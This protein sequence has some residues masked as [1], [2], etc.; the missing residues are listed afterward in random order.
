M[1]NKFTSIF[2][3]SMS[4]LLGISSVSSISQVSAEGNGGNSEGS[5][6]K[7]HLDSDLL[8]DEILTV[9]V[10]LEEEAVLQAKQQGRSQSEFRLS[11]ERERILNELAAAGGQAE[12]NQEYD[13]LFSGFSVEL[14]ESD[15]GKLLMIE[16]VKSVYPDQEYEVTDTQQFDVNEV[17]PEMLDSAPYIEAF[18]AWDAGYTG[19]GVTVAVIDTGVD[20]THPDLVHA[21]GDYKGWDFVDNDDDPQETLIEDV[22]NPA[23]A[24]NHGTHVAGTIAANGQIKG[25]APDASLLAYRVLGPGG[26]GTTSDVVA[27][28][29]RAV[30][31]GADIMNLSL[32]ATV[33]NPDF[34][35]SIALDTA[36]GEG[37]VAVTANG[38]AGPQNWTVGSPGTSR[39]AISVGA[40]QLPYNVFDASVH[41]ES[42][43]VFPSI[44]VMGYP[45][46]DALLALN[47]QTLEYVYAGLG[48][49]EDFSSI[50]VEGKI[51][52]IQRGEYPFVEKAQNAAEAGA[53]GAIL[54]NNVAGTQPEIPG[55]AVPT[56]MA[57]LEDGQKLLQDLENGFNTVTLSASFSHVVGETVADFSSRGPVM[58]NWMI[59]PDIVAPGVSIVSTVPGPAYASLQGTSMA[60][61]HVAGAAALILEAHPDWSVDYVKAALMNTAEQ[62]T[63]RNGQVYPHNT[64]G[65]GSVRVLQAIEAETLIIPGS[66]SFGIF[67]KQNG[68]EVRRQSFEIHNL[69]SSRK[70]HTVSFTGNSGIKVS[71]SNNLNIP[72]GKSNTF[73][74]NVQVDAS[75]LT[76]GYV[77]GTFLISD[78]IKTYEVPTIL[79][80]HEP[81]FPLLNDVQFGLMDGLLVGLANLT[82]DVDQ[83]SLRVRNADTGE[84]LTETSVSQN[85][86]RGEHFFVWDMLIDGQPLG[87]G[88]Y[89]LNPTAVLGERVTELDGAVLTVGP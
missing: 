9:I 19:E 43:Q 66:H 87:P 10:E 79:F 68:K 84:L 36:M 65:A 59:K 3:G 70:R 48:S 83:F 72:A 71:N 29:E 63:D 80:I 81:D 12:V 53:V 34:P 49:R 46:E 2:A 7:L 50:D 77:E 25:V 31:D 54:F 14:S 44:E 16:G 6:P 57:S 73:N 39:D 22:L 74:F 89:A 47:G 32:G 24:T 1:K 67:N 26:S 5:V 37:V 61:P 76:P 55:M 45:S 64:Q 20:Y 75:N 69:S 62:L 4:L 23:L 13:Q 30:E 40:T 35:T 56:L 78:G 28:I 88:N 86:P 21:F 82:T 52:L 27:A 15:I 41:T 51:A 17:T 85:V 60:A 33:N 58:N 11:V 18:E 8:S 42:A 38:N